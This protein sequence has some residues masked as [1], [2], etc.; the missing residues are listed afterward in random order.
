MNGCIALVVLLGTEEYWSTT[1]YLHSSQLVG[2]IIQHRCLL[3]SS[4]I[5]L[6]P[7]PTPNQTAS[8]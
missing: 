1:A 4:H 2:A 3:S 6:P 7:L 8:I 5:T